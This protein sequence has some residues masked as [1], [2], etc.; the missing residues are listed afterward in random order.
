MV[1]KCY[2]RLKEPEFFGKMADGRSGAEMFKISLEYPVIPK[3][4][5]SINDFYSHVKRTQKPS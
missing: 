2:I 1:S 4:K 5:E 3:N